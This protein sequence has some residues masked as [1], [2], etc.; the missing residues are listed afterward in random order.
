MISTTIPF[1]LTSLALGMM[2]AF[3]TQNCNARYNEARQLWGG[4]VNEGRALSSRVLAMTTAHTNSQESKQ[5]AIDLTKLLMS[6]SH[7]LKFHVTTD[8]HSPSLSIRLDMTDDEVDAAKAKALQQEL[9]TIWDY[10]NPR[11]WDIVQR[12]LQPGINR[13]LH[14]LQEL[15]E[16]NAQVFMKNS[17][18]GGAGLA[19]H[20]TDSIYR[21]ITR[22]QGEKS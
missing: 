18:E 13:P 10:D 17:E 7:A 12:I 6:F 8:G 11:E 5:A 3:R 22:F 1:S 4:M 15:A 2:L 14:I 20:H 9:A 16:L 21:S 19:P